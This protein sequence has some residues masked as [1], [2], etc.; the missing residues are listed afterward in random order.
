VI[1]ASLNDLSVPAEG[2]NFKE[3]WQKLKVFSSGKFLVGDSSDNQHV[4][5]L[6]LKKLEITFSDAISLSVGK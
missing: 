2:K 5:E 4:S 1:N 3:G 6:S